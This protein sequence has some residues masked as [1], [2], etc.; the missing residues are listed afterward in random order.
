MR[1]NMNMQC[2]VRKGCDNK[3]TL[4]GVLTSDK[5]LDAEFF[6]RFKFWARSMNPQLLYLNLEMTGDQ[7]EGEFGREDFTGY[8]VCSMLTYNMWAS[9]RKNDEGFLGGYMGVARAQNFSNEKGVYRYLLFSG[10]DDHHDLLSGDEFGFFESKNSH[11]VSKAECSSTQ[12]E[13]HRKPLDVDPCAGD[14]IQNILMK[15]VW[16]TVDGVGYRLNHALQLSDFKDFSLHALELAQYGETRT[17]GLSDRVNNVGMGAGARD[18]QYV[19]FLQH[20]KKMNSCIFDKSERLLTQ[21]EVKSIGEIS[22]QYFI[23]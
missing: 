1:E 19:S 20:H 17:E 3:V 23:A 2:Y 14:V 9:Y 8:D 22:R 5:S 7:F 12:F 13:L 21:E 4:V 10:F 6:T 18:A 15:D 11:L 16:R